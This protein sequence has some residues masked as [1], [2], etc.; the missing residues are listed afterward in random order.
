MR[1]LPGRTGRGESCG[2]SDSSLSGP[3]DSEAETGVLGWCLAGGVTLGSTHNEREQGACRGW[4]CG[5][6][7]ASR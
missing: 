4:S 3:A 6:D 7:A 1:K 2:E 5:G